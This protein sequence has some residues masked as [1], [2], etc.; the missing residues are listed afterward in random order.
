MRVIITGASSQVGDFLVPK[1]IQAGHCCFLISRSPRTED[2]LTWIKGSLKADDNFF[3]QLQ[4][5]DAWINIAPL[6]LVEPWLQK[7]ADAGIQRFIGFSTTSIYTKEN[8]PD[9]YECRVIA[10]IRKTENRIKEFCESSGIVWVLL[11]PT[12]I[13]GCGK[14]HN[15]TFIQRMIA[16]FGFFP[17]VGEACGLRQPVHAEDLADACHAALVKPEAAN[18]SF[19]LSGGE[20]LTYR[21]MVERIFQ[22]Q[23]KSPRIFNVPVPLLKLLIRLMALLPPWKHINPAMVDRINQ[24]MVFDHS[25]ASQDLDYSPRFFLQNRNRPL[26]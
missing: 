7:A 21:A 13:Y 6:Y 26:D 23:N 3:S 1:L 17:V 16:R 4:P 25:T 2:N 20:T 8:S 10:N 5:L 11:R 19:N 9:V 24:D 22:A 18:K 12:M 14:D 15:V